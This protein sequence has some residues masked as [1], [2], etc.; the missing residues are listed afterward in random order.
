MASREINEY[1]VNRL[2]TVYQ[3]YSEGDW[4]R[5]GQSVHLGGGRFLTVQHARKAHRCE[6][7]YGRIEPGQA[8]MRFRTVREHDGVPAKMTTDRCFKCVPD[9]LQIDHMTTEL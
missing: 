9:G 8:Y 6:Y 1:R 5:Y 7:C 2:G 3:C 4:R